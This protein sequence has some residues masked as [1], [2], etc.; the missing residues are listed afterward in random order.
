M[1]RDSFHY[2]PIIIITSWLLLW[3]LIHNSPLSIAFTASLESQFYYLLMVSF[4]AIGYIIASQYTKPISRNLLMTL[5]KSEK[6]ERITIFG[7][8]GITIL[9][10]ILILF[11]IDTGINTGAFTMH[12]IEYLW[13]IRSTLRHAGEIPES[14]RL[15]GAFAD[16]IFYPLIFTIWIFCLVS[17]KNRFLS[18]TLIWILVI[19]LGFSYIFQVNYSTVALMF[20]ALPY[21]YFFKRDNNKKLNKKTKKKI[22]YSILIFGTILGIVAVNRFGSPDIVGAFKKYVIHYRTLGL[23]FFDSKLHNPNSILHEPTYGRSILGW[24]DQIFVRIVKIMGFDA[25]AASTETYSETGIPIH[26]GTYN[27][28]RYYNNA[29]GTVLFTMYRDFRIAGIIGYSFIYGI[30]LAYSFSKSHKMKWK[31]IFLILFFSSLDF[32]G[33]SPF[34]QKYF[35]SS[36]FF[37]VIFCSAFLKNEKYLLPTPE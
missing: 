17:E 35:W 16:L 21:F 26:V 25:T 31:A 2:R 3:Y 7:K 33:L 37:V 15:I 23:Y 34:E 11:L 5:N 18:R 6:K 9:I 30:F 24:I 19:M 8:I 14:S 1:I 12:P 36:I 20:T 13:Y 28:E 4:M 32:T 10:I 22:L 27:G 29:F